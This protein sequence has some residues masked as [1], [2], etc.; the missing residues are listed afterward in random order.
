MEGGREGGKEGGRKGG[1]RDLLVEFLHHGG[2]AKGH[3]ETHQNNKP[4]VSG[5]PLLDV[6]LGCVC[7]EGGEE[8]WRDEGEGGREGGREVETN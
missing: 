3:A 2:D 7:G 4:Q 5:D 1:K 8:A 6:L